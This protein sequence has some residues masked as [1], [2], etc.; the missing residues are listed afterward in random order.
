M[1]HDIYLA[2][3]LFG[4]AERSFNRLL[5]DELI[6]RGYRVFVPQ[7]HPQGDAE[8]KE[9]FDRDVHALQNA[10][11]VVANLD[12]PDPD[13]GTCWECGYAYGI[14]KPVVAFRTDVRPNEEGDKTPVNL[15]LAVSANSMIDLRSKKPHAN[16]QELLQEIVKAIT[17]FLGLP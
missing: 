17:P 12:G 4:I 13:S 9:I 14:G 3:P 8:A 5:A 1:K 15:M 11:V 7:D 10:S 2:G 16:M 6:Y